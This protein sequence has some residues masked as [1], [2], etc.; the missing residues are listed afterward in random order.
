M[1]PLLL[2]LLLVTLPAAAIATPREIGRGDPLRSVLLDA[3]RQSVEANLGQ[4]LIF[5][6]DE[7]RVEDAWAFATVA[8]RT[9]AGA[10]VDFS[11][12]PHAERQREGMLDG[13]TIYALLRREGG[14]WRV[15]TWVIGPTDVTYAGWP[16][17]FGAPWSLFG[18]PEP[19]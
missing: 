4:K 19:D 10:S 3:L 8:P 18:L 7:L 16:E 14:N 15:V 17:E 9:P 2:A 11:R 6:V 13:D 12:T 1:R 5:V